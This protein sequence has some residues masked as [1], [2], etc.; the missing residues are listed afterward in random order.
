MA[1]PPRGGARLKS[2]PRRGSQKGHFRCRR[3]SGKVAL[4]KGAF[5]VGD[6]LEQKYFAV[7]AAAALHA[8]CAIWNYHILQPS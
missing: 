8:C 3:S 7:A 1:G 6:R 2:S 5:G 4:S